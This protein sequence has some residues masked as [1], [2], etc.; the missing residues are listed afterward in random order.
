ML[1]QEEDTPRVER[2][3][4]DVHKCRCE[5]QNPHCRCSEREFLSCA[6]RAVIVALLRLDLLTSQNLNRRQ[7]FA[8]RGVVHQEEDDNDTNCARDSCAKESPLPAR[9]GNDRAYK[10]EREPLADVVA[11]REESVECAST[12]EWEPAREGDNCRCSTHRLRPTVDTPHYS[13]DY[14]YCSR[15][16]SGITSKSCACAEQTYNAHCQVCQ[17]RYQQTCCH[18]TLDV[19]V[20]CQESVYE[21]TDCVRKEECRADNTQLGCIEHSAIED[22]LLHHIE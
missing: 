12:R 7:T 1:L 22:R 5:S 14:E 2:V 8:L 11:C 10:D 21:L 17:G 18:K 13:E 9:N 4:R 15:R 6:S 3:A 19:R 16:N 20:V